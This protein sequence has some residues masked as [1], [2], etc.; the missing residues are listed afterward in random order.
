MIKGSVKEEDV[1]IVNIGV[2]QNIRL[3]LVQ[4]QIKEEIN[5]NTVI[6]GDSNTP[7]SSMGRS[8]RKKNKK[9]AQALNFTLKQIDLTAIHPK[10]A[11]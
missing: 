1:T 4:M 10:A 3:T 7:L 5:S 8:F 6:V 11:E 9:K 2:L